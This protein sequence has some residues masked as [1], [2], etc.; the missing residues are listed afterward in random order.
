MRF[1]ELFFYGFKHKIRY[2]KQKQNENNISK[3]VYKEN[4]SRDE[5]TLQQRKVD[6]KF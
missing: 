6:S 4:C 3:S 1:N 5:E 2:R